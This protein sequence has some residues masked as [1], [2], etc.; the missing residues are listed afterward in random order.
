MNG[1]SAAPAA[2]GDTVRKV[3]ARKGGVFGRLHAAL[4][5]PGVE[6]IDDASDLRRVLPHLIGIGIVTN[7]LALALPLALLQT[8]DR[9]IPNQSYSTFAL[10]LG[11]V[12]A[13]L[14]LEAALKVLRGA[15]MGWLGARFEHRIGLAALGHVFGMPLREYLK[16][17]P[18]GY[19]ERLRS[20]AQVREFY[21]G[22]VIALLIDLPFA[23]LY[24]G[25]IGFIGGWLV[26]VPLILLLT[27]SIIVIRSGRW[28]RGQVD[29]RTTLDKRRFNFLSETLAGIHSVKMLAMEALM[30]RRYERLQEASVEKGAE[31]ARGS[32]MAAAMG[33]TFTQLMII[34][35]VGGGALVVI[36]G[37]M[38]PGALAACILF[39]VRALQPLRKSLSLWMRY[40]GILTAR[41]ALAELFLRPSDAST[42]KP[43][44]PPL[45]QGLELRDVVV[46]RPGK[47]GPLFS[48]LSLSV[49]IGECVAILGDSGSG[50]TALLNLLNGMARPDAGAVLADGT[51]LE[52]FDQQSIPAH[53]AFLPQQSSLLRGTILENITMF[54]PALNDAALAVAKALGMD[55]VVAG[56][57]KG[58]ETPVGE[59]ASDQLPAGIRQRIAIARAL[60]GDPSVILFDEANMALDA[61]GDNA[62][63]AYLEQ[64][65]GRKSIVLVTHRP[66]L[67]SLADRRLE[68]R[69]GRLNPMAEGN[70]LRMAA[71][72]Q[73]VEGEDTRIEAPRPS[74]DAWDVSHCLD[75]FEE[76]SDIAACLPPLLAALDWRGTPRELAEALPHLVPTLDVS[77]LR[78]ALSNLGY[79]SESYGAR[80]NRLQPALLPCLFIAEHGPARLVLQIHDDGRLTAFD[81]DTLEIMTFMPS[82]ERGEAY[83]FLKAEEKD[84]PDAIAKA[85]EPWTRGVIRRFRRLGLL[86]LAI[87]V[88]STV[89][90]LGPPIFVKSVFDQV[91]PSMAY[92]L[93]FYLVLGALIAAA[94]DWWLRT[95]KSRILSHMAGRSEYIVGI[96]VFQRIL[97]L[98]AAST[99]RATVGQQ[100]GRIKDLESLREFFLGPLALLVFELPA[101]IIYVVVLAFLNP[102]VIL[103]VAVAVA[104]FAVLGLATRSGQHRR[105]LTAGAASSDRWEFVTEALGQLRTIRSVGATERW[106]KRYRDLSGR[107]AMAEYSGAQFSE[108]VSATAQFIGMT[109]GVAAMAV[110][111]LGA[112]TGDLTGGAVMASMMIVWRLVGPLQNG[113]V[114][115]TTVARVGDSLRQLNNLMKLQVEREAGA[116]QTIRP[117]AKGEVSFQRVSFRYSPEADPALLGVTFTVPAGKV[118]A[119]AGPNGA[120]KSTVLKMIVRAFAPQAGAIRID[121]VDVR[122]LSPTDL[123]SQISYMPQNCDLFYGTV[124]QNM[125]LSHP[126]ATNEE[127]EWALGM[128]DLLH[129]VKALPQGIHTRISDAHGTEL[130]NGFRQRL[131]LARTL[132][133]PAPIVLLDEPGN[134]LD[135][136][137]DRA[138]L[139][140]IDWLRG[141]STVFIVSHR[142]SHMRAADAVLFFEGGTLKAVGPFDDVKKTVMAGLA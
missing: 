118:A 56:F 113:F 35:V 88:A 123:R 8:Y 69:D 96:N 36:S 114:A 67:L 7:L 100:I 121:G 72:S 3:R 76:T 79:R 80:L 30:H 94:L 95:L 91:L 99:E 41:Q 17:E 90:S 66:S 119:I 23:V 81:G 32:A 55:G 98:P 62:L 138:L 131:S 40:Q 29:H 105:T 65:K 86:T 46:E 141:R 125:R 48:G 87:T 5:P 49:G 129:D 60:V 68:L 112:M 124:A 15:I 12:V 52:S 83:V 84:T 19:A 101:T 122:Q 103:V 137:G 92:D 50:K 139:A 44:L 64:I 120:G 133:K 2:G 142:P 26:L 45:R 102:W 104:L 38:T 75:Y 97:G 117:L 16:D 82:A 85:N 73:G 24:L 89:L 28:M 57:R 39:S 9:I 22:Q 43:A 110:S 135:A 71:S 1:A 136:D 20:T 42:A 13:A 34:M 134:G 116:R 93:G 31:L 130:P 37:G 54:N 126:T 25:V 109:A 128:A 115:A 18:G 6:V 106:L 58:Y 10:L 63:R 61:G 51:P 53:I 107:S 33:T 59:G 11:G 74:L 14:A 70:V 111:V 140:A 127:L 77:G 108:R 21:S 4:H 78:G 132:L 47:A 27:F